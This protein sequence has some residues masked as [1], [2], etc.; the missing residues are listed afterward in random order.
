MI[1]I[2][3]LVGVKIYKGG[4]GTSTEKNRLST[5]VNKISKS[6]LLNFDVIDINSPIMEKIKTNDG[7]YAWAGLKKIQQKGFGRIDF[8]DILIIFSENM[9]AHYLTYLF[10]IDDFEE[11]I[12]KQKWSS[13]KGWEKVIIFKKSLE[14]DLDLDTFNEIKKLCEIDEVSVGFSSFK[15]NKD[16]VNKL[17]LERILSKCYTNLSSKYIQEFNY[18]SKNIILYG[19]PGTGKTFSTKFEAIK[20]I[21][22]GLN[23]SK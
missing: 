21:E 9:K 7:F 15:V 13:G 6:E 16:V 1:S 22:G 19:P 23:E 12:A 8:N 18:L 5:L 20:I 2:D 11:K 10:D 3:N 17:E 4:E 14:I